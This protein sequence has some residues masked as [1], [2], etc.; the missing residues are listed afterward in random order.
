[1]SASSIISAARARARSSLDEREGKQILS[2]FQVPVPRSTV[3]SG[4]EDLEKALAPLTP[5]FAVKVMSAQILHKSDAGGVRLNLASVEAVAETIDTMA[6]SPGIRDTLVDGYLVEEMAPNGTEVVVGAVRDPTF[7]PLLMVGLGGI[8]VEVLGDVAF[9]LCPISRTDAMSMLDELRG[10]QV[11]DGVRGQPGVDKQAVVDILLAVGGQNGLLMSLQDDLAELDIN[12]I[13]ATETAAMA[14]DARF[15]LSHERHADPQVDSALP[16]K[17]RDGLAVVERFTPLFEPKSIAVLGA[18]TTQT[19]IANTFIRRLRDFN[20]PGAIYPIH[21]RADTVEGLP[22]FPALSQTPEPVD[23][24][25]IGISANRIPDVLAEAQGNLKFAHVISS[26]FSEVPEGQALETELVEKGHLGGC[27]IIGPNCLGLYS[28]RGGVTF[29]VDAPDDVGTIGVISQSGGL[30]TDIIKRG[31]WRGL[32]FSGL[33]TVGNS[34]DIGPVDLFEY[35]LHDHQTRAI[36]MY[37]EDIKDGRR[38]FDLMHSSEASKPVVI[39]R[40]GVSKLGQQA[41][42][43]H[44]GALA[45]DQRCWDAL[46]QQ[47]GCVLVANVDDFINA[48]LAFQLLDL[49]TGRPT[50]R[51]ALFG[52]GGGTGVLATDCFATLGLDVTP[53]SGN[54]RQQLENMALPPGT[55]V[56]N[57]IDTPVRTLQEQDGQVAGRILDIVYRHADPDAVVMH[58]NLASFVGRGGVD[59]V[60]NLI[61]AGE[62]VRRQYP[63]GAHFVMVLRVDGSPELDESMRRYRD[64]ILAAGVPVFDELE[65]AAKALH[66]VS[67]VERHSPDQSDAA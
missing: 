52:N 22:C 55:S 39:L 44:T 23:Y 64:R 46:A 54:A 32:R 14:V 66:A 40:G 19:S 35:F 3:V 34:A 11:L 18:S 31:Q 36:G 53:F 6:C 12:P 33:V 10:A 67:W 17:P 51:V 49:R 5:P 16:C 21:P 26:G 56:A 63:K 27:R 15:I 42:V 65:P 29:S 13:I 43:S 61:A 24:A 50:R 47:T 62:R 2:Q 41:A 45:G 38:F 4:T 60:D 59:P 30:G 20:Y 7:G 9:R 57:P 48:L 1:M 8:F 37:L 25:Y 28:P 58:L